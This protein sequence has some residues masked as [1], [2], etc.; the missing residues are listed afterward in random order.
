MTDGRG[1]PDSHDC[2]DDVAAYALGA[3]DPQETERFEQHLQSCAVCRDELVAFTQVVDVLP[4]TAPTHQAPP[5]LRHRVL[6]AAAD[7]P[8]GSTAHA[9]RVR[10]PRARPR[11]RP[12]FR[13]PRVALAAALAIAVAVFGGLE[14]TSS[15]SPVSRVI[16]AQTTGG[17]AAELRLTGHR[18]E[19]VLHHFSPPPAGEMYEVWLQRPGGAP[20]PTTAL[21]SVNAAGSGDVNIPGNLRGVSLIMVT[22]EPAGGTLKPTHPAVIT[23]SLT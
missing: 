2:G 21:F 10:P 8:R 20:Q 6:R 11:L 12:L 17:G 23:A 3:L 5:G 16:H 4:M 7:E 14:L 13:S 18:G 15:S 1:S 19:L 22:P 9:A